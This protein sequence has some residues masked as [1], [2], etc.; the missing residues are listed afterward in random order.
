MLLRLGILIGCAV[1]HGGEIH[2]H[3]VCISRTR[4]V[5]EFSLIEAYNTDMPPGYGYGC[6]MALEK[7]TE[8]VLLR[9]YI[10]SK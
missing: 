8:N 1:R 2:V 5:A 9:T 10:R 3:Y 6:N 4:E 7:H